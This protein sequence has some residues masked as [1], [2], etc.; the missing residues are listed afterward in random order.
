MLVAIL[1]SVLFV[2]CATSPEIPS[3]NLP[4]DPILNAKGGIEKEVKDHSFRN[5]RIAYTDFL[6]LPP[7]YPPGYL[8]NERCFTGEIFSKNPASS[9]SSGNL[10]FVPKDYQKILESSFFQ[11]FR[12]SGF[13]IK[14]H[15]SV[16]EAKTDKAS[17]MIGGIPLIFHVENENRAI[18]KIAYKIISLPEE[19]ILWEGIIDSQFNHDQVPASIS[20]KTLVFLVGNHQFNFQPQRALLAFASHKNAMDL[21]SRIR[22]ILGDLK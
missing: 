12:A 18:V 1:L 16:Q 13:D 22:S 3:P 21:L 9:L 8:P 7:N 5:D 19:R 10:L 15:P 6:P 17:L 11:T 2:G 14:K 4:R 20:S